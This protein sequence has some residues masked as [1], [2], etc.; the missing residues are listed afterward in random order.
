MSGLSGYGLCPEQKHE[1]AQEAQRSTVQ[2]LRR[3]LECDTSEEMSAAELEAL[4]LQLKLGTCN[5]MLCVN[6]LREVEKE[7]AVLLRE[8]A[9]LEAR[10]EPEPETVSDTE[11]GPE[12]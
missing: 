7:R 8:K 4:A 9:A 10:Y 11:G 1:A 3:L 6:A 2:G 12:L 5:L